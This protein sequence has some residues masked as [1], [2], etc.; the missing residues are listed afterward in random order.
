MSDHNLQQLTALV[1]TGSNDAGCAAKLRERLTAT[2]GG[3]V[4]ATRAR[5]DVFGN[6]L[7]HLACG[8]GKKQLAQ[9]G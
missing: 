5:I 7:L 3:A 8:L 4:A 9:A 1:R 6:T 2:Q